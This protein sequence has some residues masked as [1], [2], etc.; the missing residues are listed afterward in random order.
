[1]TIRSL[2]CE[3]GATLEWRLRSVARVR[4]YPRSR[5]VFQGSPSRP[6]LPGSPGSRQPKNTSATPLL[7]FPIVL[8]NEAQIPWTALESERRMP[9]MRATRFRPALSEVVGWT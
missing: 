7:L 3:F 4:K 2:G 8:G 9:L 6:R 5:H 1:M